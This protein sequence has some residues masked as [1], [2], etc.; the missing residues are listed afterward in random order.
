MRDKPIVIQR[1]RA[2][3]RFWGRPIDIRDEK[4]GL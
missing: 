4:A 1:C 2:A 3:D